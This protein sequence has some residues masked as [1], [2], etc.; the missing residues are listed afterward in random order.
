MDSCR[1]GC[2]FLLIYGSPE[3]SEKEE[4]RTIGEFTGQNGAVALWFPEAHMQTEAGMQS[5]PSHA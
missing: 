3:K 5:T 4:E 1:V 2:V